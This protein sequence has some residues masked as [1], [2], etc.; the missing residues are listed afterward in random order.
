MGNTVS[1]G[2]F[3]KCVSSL[4][5]FAVRYGR[6]KQ[7][8][9]KILWI[10]IVIVLMHSLLQAGT[11]VWVNVKG[12]AGGYIDQVAVD[13][14]K[15]STVY[16]VTTGRGLY[17]STDAGATWHRPGL[18]MFDSPYRIAIDPTNT[19]I[20]YMAA[21]YTL[22]KSTD[23]GSNW[24][25][26]GTGLGN[27]FI[28][29][30]EVDPSNPSVVYVCALLD[31]VYKSIN[32]G[33][34]WT[35][36]SNGLGN[37]DLRKL[38]VDPTNSDVLYVAT[39]GGIY[40][41]FNAGGNWAVQN[42]GLV[43]LDMN[44]VAVDPQQPLVLYAGGK[45]GVQKSING[46]GSWTDVDGGGFVYVDSVV[47]DPS[48]PA[49]IYADSYRSTDFGA[50]W[51]SMNVGDGV[52]SSLA[53]N[54]ISAST[55]YAA[56]T[57]DGVAKSTDSGATWTNVS[58]GIASMVVNGF[59][60]HSTASFSATTDGVYYSPDGGKNWGVAGSRPQNPYNYDVVANPQNL[61][62]LYAASDSG[63]YKR[64]IF[65]WSLINTGLTSLGI[66][67]FSMDPTNPLILYAG[68]AYGG[69][70][71]SV[72]GSTWTESNSGLIDKHIHD[73]ALDPNTPA[74][75][76]AAT[77]AG[78]YLSTNGAA[79]W[80]YVG[81]AASKV[82]F[83]KHDPLA[84]LTAYAGINDKLYKTT[85][86]GSSWNITPGFNSQIVSFDIPGGQSTVLYACDYFQAYRSTDSGSSW[87]I[88]NAGLPY[89]GTGF[90]KVVG[91]SAVDPQSAFAG[92]SGF[93]VF[94]LVDAFFFDDYTDQDA[95][96]WSTSGGTWTAAS[97]TLT[98][99][100]TKKA[101]A[102]SPVF[103]LC[104]TCT[105]ETDFRMETAKEKMTVYS[106]YKDSK[107]YLQ[108]DID[109]THNTIKLKQKQA[110][111]ILWTITASV[112][113]T[114]QVL[115]HL[116]ISYDGAA[117]HVALEDNELINKSAT[118]SSAGK[119]GFVVKANNGVNTTGRFD[120]VVVY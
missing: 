10:S 104:A 83:V 108:L 67:K 90:M 119:I 57:Q 35:L 40:R 116:A 48:S 120:N 113:L 82:T 75:L 59:D 39:G 56:L 100:T 17:K 98:A 9:K 53:V 64:G 6:R 110:G 61:A 2:T 106:W 47:I 91:G 71:K 84:S 36:A 26:S 41:S 1:T 62:T 44:S 38:T 97:K 89:R 76:Y 11:P 18:S 51:T 4:S 102:F 68:T 65:G 81:P 24:T 50:T 92:T 34:Q 85:N 74:R 19:N 72:N 69:V 111:T 96:D 3:P 80:S 105:M 23:G 94:R 114:P 7:N 87:T 30:V 60:L 21:S 22:Y 25:A 43:S 16:A 99:A 28:R 52:V 8:M 49:N 12:L 77:D 33:G 66:R 112:D 37:L 54:P 95:S 14:Q 118:V 86:G 13:P 117:V 78:V 5:L 45:D 70:F 73:L 31:G 32:A 55:I 20:L 27:A 88:I 46:S 29:D 42:A 107:N 63:V 109:E 101:K 103:A 15:P 115:Y 93:G 79:G 58:T